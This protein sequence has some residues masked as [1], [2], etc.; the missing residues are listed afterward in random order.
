MKEISK[1]SIPAQ[2]WALRH[3]GKVGPRTFRVLLARFTRMEEIFKAEIPELIEIDGLGETRCLRI[4]ESDK[5]LDESEDYLKSL[6]SR[7]INFST[8]YDKNY[9]ALFEELNDPPPIIFYHGRLPQKSEKTVAIVGSHKATSEGIGYAV[10]LSKALS[11]KSISIISGLAPGIDT[12]AHIGTLKNDG[13]TYAILGAGL[14]SIYEEDKRSLAT[15]IL[16]DGGII[17]EY[18][19]ETGYSV[20]GLMARNRLIVG[21]S[22]AVVIGEVMADSTGTKDTARLCHE[23]GKLM[24]IMIDGCERPGR[25]NK[26][27]DEILALG[28]IPISLSDGIDL[29]VKSLV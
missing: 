4:Y 2:V 7:N 17:S 9:P 5:Y 16:K 11:E 24:F 20:G 6:K 21:L 13:R 15:E 26:A 12:A 10:E 3:Y 23:L 14:E 28:A 1:Y 18:P 19:L 27:V 8:L 22:Q 29:I 25:D